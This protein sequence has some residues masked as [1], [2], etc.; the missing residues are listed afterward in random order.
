MR[1]TPENIAAFT[2]L[3]IIA[4]KEAKRPKEGPRLKEADRRRLLTPPET[5]RSKMPWIK[6]VHFDN[7]FKKK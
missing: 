6:A 1:R 5:W 7:P 3:Y 4:C 2:E